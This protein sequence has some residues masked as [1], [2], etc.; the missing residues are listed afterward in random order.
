MLGLRSRREQRQVV[1]SRCDPAGRVAARLELGEHRLRARDDGRRQARQLGDGDPVAAVG[2]TARD[3]VEEDEVALP[4]AR[5]DVVE[6]QRSRAARRA[7]SARDSGSRTVCG[8]SRWSCI[9][10]TTAQAIARP[11]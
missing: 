2:G 5:A 3:F 8:T 4:L 1:E 7:A 10:S 9:A 11:S 6:R